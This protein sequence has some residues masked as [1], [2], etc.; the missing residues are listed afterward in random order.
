MSTIIRIT[1]PP[2]VPNGPEILV[3]EGDIQDTAFYAEA[4]SEL[5]KLHESKDD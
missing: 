3:L 5:T 1:R 2:T 4:Q